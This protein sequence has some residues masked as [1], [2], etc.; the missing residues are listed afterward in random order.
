MARRHLR[1][2][3]TVG[4]P[5]MRRA[6]PLCASSSARRVSYGG[7]ERPRRRPARVSGSTCPT[8]SL[9][10]S[11][12]AWGRAKT[13]NPDARIFAPSGADALRTSIG[14]LVGQR[15]IAVTANVYSHV[16][17]GEAEIDYAELLR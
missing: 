15:D 2:L 8:C 12:R 4:L 16:I 3:L 17:I 10:R 11:N 7:Y 5:A 6:R 14:Q 1:L 9:T 13:A